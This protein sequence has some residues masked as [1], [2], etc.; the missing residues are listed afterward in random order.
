MVLQARGLVRR[1]DVDTGGLR[2]TP[3]LAVD[4]VDLDLAAGETLG[5]VG[6]SGS[7]KSTLAT[8]LA[9][10]LRPSSGTV[11]VHGRRL[12]GLRGRALRA[13]RREV[14]L[15]AQDPFD[16]LDP[17]R[18]AEDAVREALDLRPEPPPRAQ[19]PA[20]VR[21]L[22]DRVGLATTLTGRRPHELSGGQRQRV[23][24]ARALATGASVLVCD[25]P[26][27]ALDVSVQA[28]V[29]NLLGELQ[30]DLG[31]ACVFVSHDLG[32]VSHV[33]DRIAVMYLGRLVE[34]GP[35]DAVHDTPAHPYTAALLAAVPG[36]GS[37][38]GTR[39]PGEPPSPLQPP[40]GCPFHPRCVHA[41]ERCADD[42]PVPVDAVGAG[43]RGAAC[44][45]PLG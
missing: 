18:T 37:A 2:R 42:V 12:D 13:V 5:I 10:L 1:F 27:S 25:E 6:E 34:T 20:R 44:H 11:A 29:I 8:M 45:F 15:V 31:V 40:S 30:R 33:S 32:V 21:E 3:L 26:V 36:S 14:Q 43:P 23:V 41:R 22:F 9:G 39:L 38:R 19:R 7:G 4:G 17:R 35:R 24:L 28:Q 16:A